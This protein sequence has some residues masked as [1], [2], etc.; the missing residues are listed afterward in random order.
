MA[1]TGERDAPGKILFLAKSPSLN[2]TF[3]F[4]HLTTAAT[5]RC[6]ATPAARWQYAQ[7]HETTDDASL[8]TGISP[9]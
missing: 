5:H 2:P 9:R 8:V 4:V 7:C 6:F 1:Q 3:G